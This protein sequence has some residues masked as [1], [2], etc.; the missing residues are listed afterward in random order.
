M[1]ARQPD[2]IDRMLDPVQAGTRGKHPAGKDAFKLVVQF[3]LVDLD[4][5]IGLRCFG[6]RAAVTGPRFQPQRAELHHFIDRH[7]KGNDP[8]GDFIETGKIGKSIDDPLGPHGGTCQAQ[9][10][11]QQSRPKARTPGTWQREAGLGPYHVRSARND[12]LALAA[13]GGKIMESRTCHT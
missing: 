7:R 10:S 9:H 13:K 1:A 4:K 12:P 5:G 11:A 6:D 2:V 3:D 8:A